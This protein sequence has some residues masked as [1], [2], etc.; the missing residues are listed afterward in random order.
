MLETRNQC[1]WGGF[2]IRKYKEIMK[3]AYLKSISISDVVDNNTSRL[4]VRIRRDRLQVHI[5]AIVKL[6]PVTERVKH[7]EAPEH[8]LEA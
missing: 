5:F 1:F 8:P 6:F 4:A 7:K 3:K 2:I